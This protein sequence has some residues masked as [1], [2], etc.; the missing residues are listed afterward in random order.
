MSRYSEKLERRREEAAREAQKN[1]KE[2]RHARLASAAAAA[3]A[4]PPP[5]QETPPPA[6]EFCMPA[7]VPGRLVLNV[8]DVLDR[9]DVAVTAADDL[10]SVSVK[11]WAKSEAL[12]I[13]N[14]LWATREKLRGMVARAKRFYVITQQEG[15]DHA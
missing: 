9:F 6:P 8:S 14:S 4:A 13:R 10:V 7:N 11:G 3:L 2:A 5:V 15:Q 1:E 12:S